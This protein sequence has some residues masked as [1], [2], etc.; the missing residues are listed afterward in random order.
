MPNA[1]DISW[2]KAQFGETIATAVR[3]TPF[4]V[5]MLTALACQETGEIW[6]HLRRKPGMTPERVAALCCGDTLD[7]DRGRRAFPRFKEDL[8]AAP[9]GAAMFAIARKALLD[10][11]EFVPAYAFARDRPKKFA[12]GFGVFQ[13]DLQFFLTN[14][15]Y[16]LQRRYEDFPQSLGRALAELKSGLRRLGLQDRAA[17]SDTEFCHVAICYNTGGFTPSRGLRQGH[18]VDGVFYGERIRD[19]LVKVRAVPPPGAMRRA[20]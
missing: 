14:P 13:Y 19:L 10:M 20:P 16:F 4:D 7:A 12:H 3:G 1:S 6:S 11:A 15:D 17:I 18:R 9:N 2:F 5:D 8:V